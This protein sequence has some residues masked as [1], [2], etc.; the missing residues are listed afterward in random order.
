MLSATVEEL[1]ES[2]MKASKSGVFIIESLSL[3]DESEKRLE[4]KM[5]QEMLKLLEIP[6]EYKYIRTSTELEVMVE[7]FRS[8]SGLKY[9]HVSCHG[10]DSELGLTLD[11][12]PFDN[13]TQKFGL[14]EKRRLFVSACSVCNDR[15]ADSLAPTGLLSVI[16][17]SE[18]I[19]FDDAAIFYTAFYHRMFNADK[20]RMK[21]DQV[22]FTLDKLTE[23][24]GIGMNAFFRKKSGTYRKR[25]F[26][27]TSS[28]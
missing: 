19:E 5:L 25:T 21:N 24:L 3:E 7:R 26:A 16:G 11:T 10:N 17:P 28:E 4:G 20:D 2:V 27:P 12:V 14:L 8:K 15:L 9:L 23:L 13:L 22:E 18:D 1:R 6:S